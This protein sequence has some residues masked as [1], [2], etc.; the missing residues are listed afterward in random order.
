MYGKLLKYLSYLFIFLAGFEFVLDHLFGIVTLFKPYRLVGLTLIALGFFYKM[1]KKEGIIP[2]REDYLL[3]FN[4]IIGL[5]ILGSVLGLG[6]SLK[7]TSFLGLANGWIILL[8]YLYFSRQKINSKELE[9]Y[10]I[11]FLSALVINALYINFQAYY[12]GLFARYS[13]FFKNP[14]F[15][16]FALNVSSYIILYKIFQK[17]FSLKSIFWLVLLFN[18]V[19][20]LLATGSRSGIGSLIIFSTIYIIIFTSFKTKLQ[21]GI[22]TILISPFFLQS[23][24]FSTMDSTNNVGINRFNKLLDVEE[25]SKDPRLYIWRAGI[26]AG[27]EVFFMGIGPFQFKENF[28]RHLRKIPNVPYSES[29][30]LRNDKGLGLHNYYLTVLIEY[31]FI[32]FLFF[33]TFISVKMIRNVKRLWKYKD[34]LSALRLIIF[35]NMILLMFTSNAQLSPFF[36]TLMALCNINLVRPVAIQKKRIS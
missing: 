4:Q 1:K 26:E 12:L 30:S 16:A 7:F 5:V 36:W 21:L 6:G 27:K 17:G 19:L 13:G 9:I 28:A 20:G 2:Y 25:T 15:C 22:I 35:F 3:I 32:P 34:G 31:G 24:F 14:N 11:I 18:Q 23:S 33:I 29:A 10:L 8:T